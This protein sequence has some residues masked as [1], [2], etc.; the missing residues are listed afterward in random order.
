MSMAGT[1]ESVAPARVD[2]PAQRSLAPLLLVPAIIFV[3]IQMVLPIVILFRYSLNRFDPVSLMIDD[4]TVA[5]YVKFF[6]DRYYFDVLWRTIR[7]SLVTTVG[8]LLLGFPLAWKLARMRSKWKNLVVI[9]IVLPLFLSNAVRSAGWIVLF[10]TKGLI[11]TSLMGVGLIDAPLTIMYTETAVV[12]G[13]LA[14]NLPFMV[15]TLQ[16]VIESIDRNVEEAALSLGAPPSQAFLR[17]VWPLALPGTIAG[18]IL[19]FILAMNAYATPV[20]LGGPKFQM[21]GPLVFQQFAQQNNWPFGAAVSF[22]L[23]TATLFLSVAAQ[24]IMRRKK[25]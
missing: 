4:V 6:T 2:E 17:V 13:I 23:M 3:A 12:I 1:A 22:V 8:C 24:L 14:V 15:L 11:N 18:T 9:L 7:V 20:L 10:G 16:S 19:T 25:R 5:N 21:M